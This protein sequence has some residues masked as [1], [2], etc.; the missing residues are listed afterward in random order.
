MSYT[1]YYV[2]YHHEID[3]LFRRYVQ[4]I[5]EKDPTVMTL[6]M[7]RISGTVVCCL[8]AYSCCSGWREAYN[9]WRKEGM[10][11][12]DT[13]QRISSYLSFPDVSQ[14]KLCFDIFE[15]HT[16]PWYKELERYRG[17]LLVYVLN[18]RHLLY[19]TGF[20]KQLHQPILLLSEYELPDDTDLPDYVTAF[21]VESGSSGRYTN[22]FVEN[23]FPNLFVCFDTFSSLL[24]ILHPKGVVLLEGGSLQAHVLATVSESCNIPSYCIQQGWPSFFH[25]MFREMPY[26]YFLTWG[27]AFSTLWQSTNPKPE[28]IP[29]GYTLPV[30][31]ER[32][33][34]S[35]NCITFFLQGPFFIS[36]AHYEEEV[37]ALIKNTALRMPEQRFLVKP[38]PAYRPSGHTFEQLFLLTNVEDASFVNV[39]EV[40]LQTLVSVSHYSSTLVEGVIHGCLPL[41]Y[42]PTTGSRYRP[43]IENLELG[44]IASTPSE[45]YEKL[46][47]IISRKNFFY[48]K[49]DEIRKHWFA[50]SGEEALANAVRVIDAHSE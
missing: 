6:G 30:S 48:S 34:E 3:C 40:F 16:H 47:Q 44:L 7:H 19:L 21:T 8:F 45:F 33:K 29:I 1:D 49:A 28:F 50:A 42:D 17:Q 39:E 10:T 36:D 4:E 46:L 22:P 27:K 15:A 25:T 11:K 38:H 13:L 31:A 37:V 24:E 5:E 26:R 41:V 2:E 23:H 18:K 9:Q 20:I 14:A 32:K 35:K 12:E 43:D